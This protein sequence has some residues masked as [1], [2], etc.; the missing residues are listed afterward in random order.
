MCKY[1]YH[2][3][4]QCG[5]IATF[6][7]DSCWRLVEQLR[8]GPTQVTNCLNIERHDL[9]PQD[10]AYM[11]NQ[12]RPAYLE[13]IREKQ[14]KSMRPSSETSDTS[15]S[16][17]A[18]TQLEGLGDSFI[19][20]TADFKMTVEQE[21]RAVYLSPD[22]ESRQ[23]EAKASP[24]ELPGSDNRPSSPPSAFTFFEV[25]KYEP[26]AKKNSPAAPAAAPVP[27]PVP[28]DDDVSDIWL[29]ISQPRESSGFYDSDSDDTYPDLGEVT[30]SEEEEEQPEAKPQEEKSKPEE[31]RSF[32]G[33]AFIPFM[34][35]PASPKG[36]FRSAADP[37]LDIV[38][39]DPRVKE[40]WYPFCNSPLK[41][42][43]APRTFLQSPTPRRTRI[44]HILDPSEYDDDVKSL[45][46]G[47]GFQSESS[48][49]AT[50]GSVEKK[51]EVGRKVLDHIWGGPGLFG[52]GMQVRAVAFL[53]SSGTFTVAVLILINPAQINEMQ[54]PNPS[55]SN[56]RSPAEEP[57]SNTFFDVPL[58]ESPPEPSP[59]ASGGS[60]DPDDGDHYDWI[61]AQHVQQPLHE[62]EGVLVEEAEIEIA[63]YIFNND[64]DDDDSLPG[65]NSPSEDMPIPIVDM[66]AHASDLRHALIEDRLP[67]VE[68]SLEDDVWMV[69]LLG[70]ERREFSLDV[71]LG[72]WI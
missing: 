62:E 72:E 29:E 17:P 19:T 48:L 25:P 4:V 67:E 50:N 51:R 23:P 66:D 55:P 12:C 41:N 24:G 39:D 7:V 70:E 3:Y 30:D 34:S 26:R 71:Y 28:A 11:C 68:D 61:E 44:S 65:Y 10:E 69:W 52:S 40:P 27:V 64:D 36:I 8:Q 47:T 15:S 1:T 13:R 42:E 35:P 46:I 56:V 9:L 6:T 22:P 2:H 38:S 14:F 54:S 33:P 43:P 63:E 49:R 57:P 16:S 45:S 53:S 18:F 5:H 59:P 32:F 58:S 60:T 20:I 37:V 21:G 31:K